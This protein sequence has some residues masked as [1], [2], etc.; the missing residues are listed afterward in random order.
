M[1]KNAIISIM[2]I[3]LS[4]YGCERNSHKE[5][6]KI[7]KEW[8]GKEI[9]LPELYDNGNQ[10]GFSDGLKIVAKINGNCYSCL[11]NLRKWKPFM[12]N[13]PHKEKMSFYFYLVISDS[14]VYKNLNKEEIHFD[15]PIIYD[16]YNKFQ[17]ENKLNS[18]SIF[19]VMLLDS[20]NRVLLIGDPTNNKNMEYLYKKVISQTF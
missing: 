13:I 14:T 2:C 17:K 1:S 20:N 11:I 16:E 18:N 8:I 6:E 7:I 15:H 4:I 9:I 3:F 12:E 5:N 10:N 19:H